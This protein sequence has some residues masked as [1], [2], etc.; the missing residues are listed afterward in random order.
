MNAGSTE[1]D[2]VVAHVLRVISTLAY[3]PD[4][5]FLHWLGGDVEL[6][7]TAGVFTHYRIGDGPIKD[8]RKWFKNC[9]RKKICSK[10]KREKPSD[11]FDWKVKGV[12]GPFW[13]AWGKRDCWCKE[14]RSNQRSARYKK[15]KSTR[16][17]TQ[18]PSGHVLNV[19]DLIIIEIG[20]SDGRNNYMAGYKELI[21]RVLSGVL[22]E[23]GE[24]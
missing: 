17:R 1:V 11:Q 13:Q 24:G 8:G 15:Q 22:C 14:C 21:E 16:Q 18:R 4:L 20:G 6:I 10:C 7:K 2:C 3:P 9:Y 12:E 19:S 23:R 5:G